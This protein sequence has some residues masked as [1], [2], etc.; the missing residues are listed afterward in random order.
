M[1]CV[2]G[3]IAASTR[4]LVEIERV[5]ADVDEDRRRAASTKALAV[6]TKVNEGMIT[7]S[8][9]CDAARIAAISSAAVQECV[10]SAFSAPVRRSSQAQQRFV[11]SPLPAR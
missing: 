11:N 1:A 3:V 9:A 8:P 5:G 4:R 7:S 6:E 2:R 10:S